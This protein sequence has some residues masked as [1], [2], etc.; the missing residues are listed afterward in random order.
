M[1]LATPQLTKFTTSS[2]ILANYDYVD[3]LNGLGI[4]EFNLCGS[5]TSAGNNFELQTNNMRASIR[6]IYGIGTTPH[7][8]TF[9]SIPL[10]SARTAKGI[11]YFEGSLVDPHCNNMDTAHLTVQLYKYNPTTTTETPISSEITSNTIDQGNPLTFSLLIPIELTETT[12][13]IG[14]QLRIVVKIYQY[15]PSFV[16]LGTD[17]SNRDSDKI[18]VSENAQS[19]STIYVPFKISS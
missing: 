14:E 7:I 6:H 15:G 5:K 11:A 17:P 1:P 19:K 12:I 9:D 2:A 8:K 3:I 10:N 4:I 16:Y 18:T 13:A